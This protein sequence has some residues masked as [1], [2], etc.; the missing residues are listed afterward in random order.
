MQVS[1]DPALGRSKRQPTSR[2]YL[3]RPS[4][5]CVPAFSCRA[6]LPAPTSSF[7][8]GE[9]RNTTCSLC[10]NDDPQGSSLPVLLGFSRY[11]RARCNLEGKPW[12][13]LFPRSLHHSYTGPLTYSRRPHA[14]GGHIV[15]KGIVYGTVKKPG[16]ILAMPGLVVG[17]APSLLCGPGRGPASMRLRTHSVDTD[18]SGDCEGRR[19]K[20]H[21]ILSPEC[22]AEQAPIT[23]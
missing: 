20:W 17:P 9:P 16:S 12:A 18:P 10:H 23:R 3:E 19:T 21:G 6:L 15:V 5:S 13:A 7:S 11:S 2:C 8:S 1:P 14:W 22:A 4:C